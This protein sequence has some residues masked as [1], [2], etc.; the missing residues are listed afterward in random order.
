MTNRCVHCG[1]G[2]HCQC[3]L[4]HIGERQLTPEQKA[5][6]QATVHSHLTEIPE[7]AA[8]LD[9]MPGRGGSR[10]PEMRSSTPS[11]KRAPLNL[12][13]LDLADSRLKDCE[14]GQI[15]EVERLGILPYLQ[16]W[17]MLVFGELEDSGH[18]PD[19]CC[20]NSIDHTI[21][22]EIAWLITHLTQIL[23][24]HDDFPADIRR[25]RNRL[26]H[27][28]RIR[29]ER[30]TSADCPKC[31]WEMDGQGDYE[32]E[33]R[34]YPW[35]RCRGCAHTITTAAELD[36]AARAATDLVTLKYAAKELGKPFSTLRRWK[37]AGWILARGKDR[38][39]EIYSLNAIR[40]VS[41]SVEP[42]KRHTA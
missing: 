42:G 21:A 16:M 14:P 36:S 41:Q 28:L 31:G 8:Q 34:R 22:G 37:Q 25:M 2:D 6:I 5:K 10:D 7:L 15:P 9:V 39:G 40:I 27:E 29:P 38:R 3:A 30:A 19:R 20:P 24:W 32:K 26:R 11:P 1:T 23:D 4:D 13:H 35:Y 17:Q 12:G 18:H 33:L